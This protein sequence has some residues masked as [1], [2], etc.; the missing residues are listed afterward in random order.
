MLAN[1]IYFTVFIILAFVLSIAVKA[2]TRGVEAK[3]I[4]KDEK[5]I[6]FNE[7]KD[8]QKSEIINQIKELKNLYDKGILNDEEFKKAKD[9]LLK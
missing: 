3:Q 8:N 7:D 2:I 9:K 6:E 5:N 4:I 1:I